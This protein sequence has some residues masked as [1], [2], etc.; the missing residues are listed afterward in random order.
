LLHAQDGQLQSLPNVTSIDIQ[1][2]GPA[3]ISKQRI[4]AN[5][6]TAVGKPYSDLA[7]E[8]D[9]RNLYATGNVS[10]VR[11]FGEPVD[12]GVRVI[13]VVQ[14]RSSIKEVRFEG[15]TKIKTKQ[16]RKELQSKPGGN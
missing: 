7:V 12:N 13:V 16:F 11:I 10:N 5:M 9:I 1:Y 2:A 3:T 6:R 4:L 8:E 15:V 14:A